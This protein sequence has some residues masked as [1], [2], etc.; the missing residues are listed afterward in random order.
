VTVGRGQHLPAFLFIGRCHQQQ[1]R[2]AAQEADVVSAGMG[3]TVGADQ[4]GTVDGEGDI[5]VLQ[6]DIVDQLVIGALQKG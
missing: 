4:S 3:G 1:I 5:Q 6:G 2:H